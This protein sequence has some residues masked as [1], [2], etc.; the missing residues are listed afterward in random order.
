MLKTSRAI[1]ANR[2]IEANYRRAIERLIREM[3]DSCVYWL[4]AGYKAAPPRMAQDAAPAKDMQRR[5]V[6][7]GQRWIDRFDEFA[8]KLATIYAERMFNATDRAFMSAL[9]D[10]GWAVQFK[11]NP[12][13]RDALAA[14][15]EENI[16]LIKSIPQRYLLDV[17]GAV[18]RSYSAGRDLST[19]VQEMQKIGGVSFRR[20][21]LIARDQSNKANATVNRARQMELGITEAIWLHSGGGKEPRV[22]HVKANGKR[23]NIAEGCKISGEFIHPGEMI[24]CRCTSR[25]VLPF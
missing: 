13:M 23:Y 12:V 10:A 4:R 17:Q 11:M 18:M 25:P 7:L 19:M 14:T 3:T 21:S 6:E 20:A 2:G 1:H 15:I 16:A 9:K 8:P 5:M 22:D 24:N